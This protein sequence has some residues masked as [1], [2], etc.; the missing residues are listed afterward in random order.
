[1]PYDAWCF[2]FVEIQLA[3]KWYISLLTE[4]RRRA[5][6]PKPKQNEAQ[7]LSEDW[8]QFFKQRGITRPVL[9]RNRIAMTSWNACMF[10][11]FRDKEHVNTKYRTLD[12]KFSQVSGAEKVILLRHFLISGVDW[13]LIPR[14][15]VRPF[16]ISTSVMKHKSEWHNATFKFHQYYMRIGECYFVWFEALVQASKE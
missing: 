13:F 12:K 9:D 5:S 3:S 16:F 1:M 14:Y 6:Y 4:E 2:Q 7:R 8:L 11:Y 10:R 15:P